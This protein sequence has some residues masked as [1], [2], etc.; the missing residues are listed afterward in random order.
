VLGKILMK[1]E[2]LNSLEIEI[3]SFCFCFLIKLIPFKA[4]PGFI[5]MPNTT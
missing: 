1:L 2:P 5:N 3:Y 4:N